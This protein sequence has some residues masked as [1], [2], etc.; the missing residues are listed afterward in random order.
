MGPK[1]YKPAPQKA[2]HS[3]PKNR[4]VS[5][6]RQ[7]QKNQ[8][9]SSA[10]GSFLNVAFVFL[11]LHLIKELMH[12]GICRAAPLWR[13]SDTADTTPLPNLHSCALLGHTKCLKPFQKKTCD[14]PF[15]YNF[16]GNQSS[17]DA[18]ACFHPV[19]PRLHIFHFLLF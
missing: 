12:P 14:D 15:L 5:T 10:F 2:R 16:K 4:K 3:K 9:I 6:R 8:N 17:S 1:M 7:K 13:Y 18:S 19:R 11:D